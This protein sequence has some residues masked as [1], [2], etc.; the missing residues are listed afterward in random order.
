MVLFLD[1]VRKFSFKHFSQ[2]IHE[3]TKAIINE[4]V[5]GL[6]EAVDDDLRGLGALSLERIGHADNLSMAALITKGQT[7]KTIYEGGQNELVLWLYMNDV[8]SPTQLDRSGWDKVVTRVGNPCVVK[9]NQNFIGRKEVGYFDGASDGLD[10]PDHAD[11]R[12]QSNTT[13]LT[14][15]GWFYI[16]NAALLNG[17]FR[18]I[19]IKKDDSNNHIIIFIDPT[20]NK[21]VFQLNKA[22]TTIKKEVAS[23]F[24]L[25]TWFFGVWVW[26]YATN[27]LTV[28]KDGSSQTVNNWSGT[29][30]T[31]P[32]DSGMHLCYNNLAPE[33][34]FANIGCYNFKFWKNKLLSAGEVTNENT[35][36]FSISNVAL[37]EL[38]IVGF[39]TIATPPGSYTLTS[40]TTT[41]YTH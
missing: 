40:Y 14:I 17:N 2:Y 11:L 9:T 8:N 19:Y 30:P 6:P 5:K 31:L 24:S 12:V 15:S 26:D 22:G 10:S 3:I 18:I 20:S 23:M 1:I 27:T 16:V 21:I 7:C 36:K 13:G 33:T 4:F 41:S 34:A 32:S 39:C 38:P 29:S 37:A 28:Y 25:S 35:N